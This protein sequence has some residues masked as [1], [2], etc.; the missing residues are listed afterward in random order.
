[1][2]LSFLYYHD[3]LLFR[4]PTWGL[5]FKWKLSKIQIIVSNPEVVS[6]WLSRQALV[7]ELLG[8]DFRKV[9]RRIADLHMWD[10]DPWFFFVLEGLGKVV[11]APGR[12]GNPT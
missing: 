2:A 4:V 5:V 8:G 10:G 11:E 12:F 6:A 1:M 3:A 7:L 9:F